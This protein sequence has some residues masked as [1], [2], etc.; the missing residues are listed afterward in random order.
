MRFLRNLI[1]KQAYYDGVAMGC[2]EEAYWDPVRYDE[3]SLG[4]Q[5]KIELMKQQ[6]F[7]DAKAGEVVSLKLFNWREVL[8]RAEAADAADKA[9]ERAA[10]ASG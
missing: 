8:R 10:V 4:T 6:G 7:R 5:R 2:K 9:L 3:L 1:L